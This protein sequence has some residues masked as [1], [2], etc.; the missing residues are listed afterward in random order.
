MD[1]QPRVLPFPMEKWAELLVRARREGIRLEPVPRA[2]ELMRATSGTSDAV[3]FVDSE[4]CTCRAGEFGTPCKHRALWI[5]DHLALY[6]EG[7]GNQLAER[8]IA[9]Q[10][11][12]V[13]A[14]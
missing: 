6:A 9:E 4:S 7:I 2:R 12:E 3:Y 14:G 1:A 5:Y 13:L 11:G 8:A 10:S